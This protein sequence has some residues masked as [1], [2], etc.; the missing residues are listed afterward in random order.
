MSRISPATTIL[1]IF[2]VLFGLVGAYAV[3]RFTA[4]PPVAAAPPP[5]PA[6]R[7]T[8]P[9]AAAKLPSGRKISMGDIAL[10][11]MSAADAAKSK[12]AGTGY[13]TNPQQ[14]VG[15]VLRDDLDRGETFRPDMLYP[16]GTGPSLSERL[17]PG[18]RA[19]TIAIKG[20]GNLQGLAD[21]GSLV[22]IVFRTKPDDKLELPETTVT[23]LEAV[24]VLAV[25]D[26]TL[27]GSRGPTDA[28]TVTLAVNATQANALKIAEGRGDFSLALRNA[29]DGSFVSHDGPSTLEGLLKLPVRVKT[30]PRTIEIYR[31]GTKSLN[32]FD[33]PEVTPPAT[34]IPAAGNSVPASGAASV[35]QGVGG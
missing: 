30:R 13:M 6:Q 16:E 4:K 20:S 5:P 29:D 8:I 23:L 11:R 33:V 2:A 31:G 22:D 34:G 27:P 35:P 15:R 26:N 19:V 32:S 9:M 1:L 17:K 24:E 18:Y 28:D 12:Y 14:I 25:S 7:Q 10:V 21:S 3:R